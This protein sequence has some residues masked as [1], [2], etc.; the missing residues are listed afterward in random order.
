MP[1]LSQTRRHQS[2][3]QGSYSAFSIA[4]CAASRNMRI[5]GAADLRLPW[6]HAEEFGIEQLNVRCLRNGLDVPGIGERLRWHTRSDEFVVGGVSDRVAPFIRFFQN[7]STSQAPG[8][9]TAIPMIATPQSMSVSMLCH[10][11]AVSHTRIAGS[12]PSFRSFGSLRGDRR[13]R[14]RRPAPPALLSPVTSVL[15]PASAAARRLSRRRRPL[16][17]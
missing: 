11:L 4:E 13:L 3:V 16:W 9:R 14:Q 10:F 7:C 6:G 8:T 2:T 12:Q 5:L 1:L 15:D 17:G